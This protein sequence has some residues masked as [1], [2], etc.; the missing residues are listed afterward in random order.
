MLK[1]IENLNKFTDLTDSEVKIIEK[2]YSEYIDNSLA[3]ITLGSGA[4]L[5]IIQLY[6]M[7][8][9]DKIL[10]PNL[11]QLL[12]LPRIILIASSVIVICFKVIPGIKV[13]GL[14]Q[15]YILLLGCSVTS[16]LVLAITRSHPD[17][18]LMWI[19]LSVFVGG[20][21]T[22][23]N[24]WTILAVTF[25][26]PLYFLSVVH[27]QGVEGLSK[28][29]LVVVYILSFGVLSLLLKYY[30]SNLIEKLFYSKF[31]IEKI[32]NQNMALEVEKK[33]NDQK[34]EFLANTAHEIRTP[35]NGIIGL[36]ENYLMSE[37]KDYNN[38]YT[39]LT[40]SRRLSF[41]VN[42]II[43]YSKLKHLQLK[44]ENKS[45]PI[46]PLIDLTVSLLK[47][48]TSNK[49]LKLKTFNI[50]KDLYIMGDENRVLQILYNIVGNAI[51]YTEK[52]FITI[53]LRANKEKVFIDIQDTGIGIPE[54][55]INSIFD[56]YLRIENNTAVR[57]TGIGLYVTKQ[58]IKLQRG[59]IDVSSVVGEGSLFSM[60][61]IR[62]K[63]KDQQQTEIATFSN[64]YNFINDELPIVDGL[65]M[66]YIVDDDPINLKTFQN[67]L[68]E[69][70]NVRLFSNGRDLLK[71]INQNIQPDLILLDLIL[72]DI[73]GIDICTE[74][75]KKYNSHILPIV[76]ITARSKEGDLSKGLE[77]GANEFLNKPVLI[78]EL[79]TRVNNLI[80]LKN[81]YLKIIE[82]EQII[83]FI[84]ALVNI[85]ASEFVSNK[86][87]ILISNLD[88]LNSILSNIE[89]DELDQYK[90]KVI[91]LSESLKPYIDSNDVIATLINQLTKIYSNKE[92]FSS[93]IE[94]Y[95]ITPN[96]AD[97]IKLLF[98]G[99]VI[100]ERIAQKL[101]KSPS[102]VGT[103]LR[104][105]YDKVGV[106]NQAELLL[107]LKSIYID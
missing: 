46:K 61:F 97:I 49:D 99:E 56:N 22:S 100:H 41:L 59:T 53:S 90:N 68:K 36:V 11:Y 84:E 12:K 70:Y 60:S 24:K 87:N 101:N 52:G 8:I 48:L 47:P 69:N 27:Y 13:R 15:S 71:S 86:D 72:P 17:I 51:K 28:A 50:S 35:L 104:R 19:F 91:Q 107:N 20:I 93:F 7:V 45:I 58:L 88:R 57:G 54:E 64:D 85:T 23:R 39:A 26:I 96:Q 102:N 62:S 9:G 10:F 73:N 77:S 3:Y 33:I 76:I 18:S 78:D 79:K 5:L 4:I 1:K 67:Y 14:I 37:N 80:R 66:I 74:I 89:R 25:I 40:V 63:K 98:E 65:P 34:D 2:E 32:T 16:V 81:S 92:S 29:G 55:N 105:V 38:L 44:V 106:S 83:S 6:L 31:I 75:R 95:K 30:F 82:S 43:D 42:D 103:T 21:I 94:R